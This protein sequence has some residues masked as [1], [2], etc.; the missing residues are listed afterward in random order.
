MVHPVD[1]RQPCYI[2]EIDIG[3][4]GRDVLDDVLGRL[5]DRSFPDG[6]ASPVRLVRFVYVPEDAR[7]FLLCEGPSEASVRDAAR[8]AGATVLAS[9]ATMR[10]VGE[11]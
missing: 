4:L 8:A 7:C 1:T 10:I 2:V 6:S 3:R 9:G 11:S 5:R